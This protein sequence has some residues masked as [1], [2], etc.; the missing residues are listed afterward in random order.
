M[1]QDQKATPE[2]KVAKMSAKK[3]SGFKYSNV[4]EIIHVIESYCDC[5][6][7][8]QA[9][10]E[11]ANRS[12]HNLDILP[13]FYRLLETGMIL[14]KRIHA[15]PPS[16]LP[17]QSVLIDNLNEETEKIMVEGLNLWNVIPQAYF[18][19]FGFRRKTRADFLEKLYLKHGFTPHFRYSTET[20]Y[21]I[22]SGLSGER[23][24]YFSP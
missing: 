24:I 2:P 13:G 17:A 10:L 20:G 15:F 9:L 7:R 16:G 3:K 14:E 23:A 8:A 22:V 5:P 1:D 11:L 4:D 19:S 21:L 6:K 18:F 12:I